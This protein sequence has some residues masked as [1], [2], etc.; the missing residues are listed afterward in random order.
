MYH[1]E[2]GIEQL[3]RAARI[4]GEAMIECMKSVVPGMTEEQLRSIFNFVCHFKGA[5]SFG[6]PTSVRHGPREYR[7]HFPRGADILKEGELLTI[8]AG[9]EINHYSA[10]IQRTFPVSGKFT[11]EQKKNIQHPQKGPGGVHSDCEARRHHE[12]SAGDSNQGSRCRGR[13]WK[14]F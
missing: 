13:L 3:R 4:S 14:V 9:V 7:E 8:D 11:K 2:Y 10:D 5:K 6:F 12:R 1:D